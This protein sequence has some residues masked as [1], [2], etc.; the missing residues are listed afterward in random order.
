MPSSA[1]A[2]LIHVFQIRLTLETEWALVCRDSL[3][4]I[5]T[6]TW[7]HQSFDH[8]NVQGDCTLKLYSTLLNTTFVQLLLSQQFELFGNFPSSFSVSHIYVELCVWTWTVKW[9]NEIKSVRFL[10]YNAILYVLKNKCP[11]PFY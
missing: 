6:E 1:A 9:N 8:C 5:Y 11:P 3:C 10:I 4:V 2:P 7:K